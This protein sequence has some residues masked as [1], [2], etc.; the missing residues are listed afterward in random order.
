VTFKLPVNLEAMPESVSYNYLSAVANVSRL[1][2]HSNS[3]Y[4]AA[5]KKALRL[6]SELAVHSIG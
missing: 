5:G 2:R 4:L 1:N 3:G 6:A